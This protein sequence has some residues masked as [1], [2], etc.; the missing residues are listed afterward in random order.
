MGSLG[1]WNLAGASLLCLSVLA[2]SVSGLVMW[3]LRRPARGWRLAAPPRPDPLRVP[4]V[5]W[6]TAAILG[7]LF[8]L[9]GATMIAVALFDWMLVRRVPALRQLMD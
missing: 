2:L 7:L 8:P 5:T 6:V 3:W 4:L 9:A 1:W